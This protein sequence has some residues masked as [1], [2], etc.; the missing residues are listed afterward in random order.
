M[1]SLNYQASHLPK[2]MVAVAV[3]VKGTG[4]TTMSNGFKKS[5]NLLIMLGVIVL[6]FLYN[7]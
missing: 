5:T 7:S 3:V 6:S 2:L 1:K 4:C